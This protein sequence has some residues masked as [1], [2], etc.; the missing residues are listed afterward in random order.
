MNFIKVVLVFLLKKILIFHYSLSIKIYCFF[1][2]IIIA[3]MKTSFFIII[4]IIIIIVIIIIIII[5][6]FIIIEKEKIL[7]SLIS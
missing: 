4:I 5:I 3:L 2:T 1:K 7:Y 6:A